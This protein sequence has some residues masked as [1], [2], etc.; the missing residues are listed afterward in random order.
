MTVVPFRGAADRQAHE[1][2]GS[3]LRRALGRCRHAF[4]GVA[5]M[6]GMLSLLYLTGSFFMLEIYDRVLP[7]R[8]IPTLIGL[9]VIAAV[10]YFFQGLIDVVRGRVL[11]RIGASLDEAFHGRVFDILTRQPLKTRTSG[12]GLQAVR[13]L[14]QVRQFLSSL[15]PTAL[16]DLPW[17]PLYITICF[18]FHP[19]IGA[20]AVA[21]ALLLVAITALA[22]WR[23]RA[24]T[25]AASECAAARNA[26]A[27]ASRRNAEVVQAMGMGRRLGERWSEASERF[28]DAQQ[29]SSDVAGGLGAISK[30]LRIGLQSAVLGV[31][32]YLVIEQ[33]ATA[34][35]IIASSI[36]T[37]RAVAPVELAIAHWRGFV[38]ARQS[39]KRLREL[40][41]AFPQRRTP[42]ALPEPKASLSVEGVSATPPSG[43]HL[44]VHDVAFSLKAGNALGVVGPSASGKSS[45]ARVL[46]GVWPALRGKVRFDGAA[47]TQWEPEALGKHIGYL[48]QDVELFA[49]TVAENIA[50]FAPEPDASAV[51][52]AAQAAN[53]HDL[54]L[55]LP[56]G[57]ETQ[58]AE[59]GHALSAGQRQRIALA[60]AL[61]R[62]P[63]LV[64]L[65]E[66][67]SNL[68]AEG[69]QA[70][71]ASI[72]SA[73]AR[74]QIVV[75]IAHRPSALAAVDLLLVMGE[76]RVQA[77]GPKDE[78]LS[79]VVKRLPGA[80]V[81]AEGREA[82]QLAAGGTGLKVVGA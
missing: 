47:L 68:D 61:Y 16:F 30:V 25:K 13:D 48:P 73:R 64:V 51:L 59:S 81:A 71:T 20:T 80:L 74:G 10:L 8:S 63:F 1:P 49:G 56:E 19:V 33:Q 69:E 3:E 32:A 22:E 23:S 37:A 41:A 70:L 55:R 27:L 52:A 67:N 82:P 46:V 78:V 2:A 15:G 72:M 17:M 24:P 7:S 9:V 45:L 34:G 18:I 14:D 79:K 50:R 12:D 53:V 40:F 57:Y 38:S 76:G 5:L 21:G 28:I 44:V 77:F 58:V 42:L 54:I 62:D 11:S 4:L 31:G 36:L 65:D 66:P 75:V 26:L 39:W 29:R 60:R 43:Q 35:I 6:S